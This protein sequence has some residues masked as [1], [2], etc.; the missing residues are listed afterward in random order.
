MNLLTMKN[1][2]KAYT[3]KVLFKG[4][5]FSVNTGDK[6]GVIGIN[7]TGKSSLLKMIAGIDTC[8]AGLIV[9]GNNVVVNYLPQSPTFHDD[10][11]IYEHVIT[12]N[13]TEENKWSIEGDARALLDK[14]G[15]TDTSISVSSL[16]GGQKKKVA[17]AAALLS[18][19]D[20][21]VLDEPTN[22]LDNDMTEYLEDY[23]NNYRGALV[24]VTHDRYFLDRVT[25][26][27]VEIDKGY[28]YSYN[29]N[30]EG[31][32][33][34]KAERENIALATERKNQNI[35]RKEI[36]W[37]RR[38][39]R[40]RSTKQKAHIKRYEALAAE[41]MIEADKTVNLSSIASRLGNKTIELHNIS[42]SFPGLTHPLIENFSYNFLRNDRIGITGP[43]GCGKSTLMKLITGNLKP[44][45]GIIEIGETVNIGYF[46]QENEMLDDNKIVLDYVKETAEYIRTVDGYMSASTLCEEFLFDSTLQHQRIGKLSGGEKRRLYLLK[47]LAGSPNVLILDEPT[48]DLDISTLCILE[49][50]L[51][52]FQ[53]I[54]IVV[55]HDRYFLDRVVKRLFVYDGY[56]QIRQFEGSYTD[57]YL[58]YGTFANSVKSGSGSVKPAP[59]S[60]GK[61]A[62]DSSKSG[63]AEKDTAPKRA[64]NKFTF[65]EQREYDTIE[66]DIA[67]CEETIDGLDREI[68]ASTTDFTK[69]NHLMA[70]KE[71]A[72]LKLEHLMERY[73]YLTDLLESFKK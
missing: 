43:N 4:A 70:E 27:I 10:E 35:L 58:E 60:K 5:D 31:Y 50:Y 36:A 14:L 48:N 16:S 18:S 13:S 39:A 49:D 17:L 19:C 38:G 46:S 56:G 47:I 52:T 37:I 12:A 23:L 32:L 9:K 42:K 24:M 62:A 41:E 64:K 33:M 21:L 34:L 67:A 26:R 1:I 2:H 7:G 30:Y 73:V 28:I 15:F 71:N 69:L 65:N 61:P 45:S 57:Y 11:T 53:G 6:I 40:A 66:D 68:A 59:A 55:S 51:D 22:H 72:E 25:N 8:D 29:A 63:A 20:I 44:D 54:L 3:D